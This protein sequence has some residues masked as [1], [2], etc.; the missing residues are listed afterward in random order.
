MKIKKQHIIIGFIIILIFI[1]GLSLFN[2]NHKKVSHRVNTEI[3]NQNKFFQDNKTEIK[4]SEEQV[5]ENDKKEEI[6][7][8]KVFLTVLGKEYKTD[9]K[10]NSSAFEAME[11]IQKENKN[12]FNFKYTNNASLGN[13]ITEINGAKGTPGKYWIYYVNNKKASVGVSNY[14]LNDGDIITWSQE[15]I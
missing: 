1:I 3:Q 7:S 5:K 9:I 15:S 4:T 8:I 11:K 6:N 12:S 10:E 2:S 14:V 13:F